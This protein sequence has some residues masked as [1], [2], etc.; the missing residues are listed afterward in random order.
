METVKIECRCKDC[1]HSETRS[2]GSIDLYCYYW[3][4]EAG[5]SPNVVDKEEFCCNAVLKQK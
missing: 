4:Y 3:D 1:E 5:M 2:L